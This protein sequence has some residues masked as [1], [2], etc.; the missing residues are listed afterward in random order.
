M[1]SFD[2]IQIFTTLQVGRY[3]LISFL[4]RPNVEELEPFCVRVHNG[5]E[6]DLLIQLCGSSQSQYVHLYYLYSDMM[7][8]YIYHRMIIKS[9][10][11][12]I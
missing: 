6:T 3:P 10:L 9:I 5:R 12:M 4:H 1:R 8:I 7:F 2:L 11:I